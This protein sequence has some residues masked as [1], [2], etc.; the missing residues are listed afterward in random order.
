MEP[1]DPSPVDH[2]TFQAMVAPHVGR[3]LAYLDRH[4]PARLRSFV[5]PQDVAQD[6][7]FEAA[8]SWHRVTLDG[9]ESVWR[10]LVTIARHRLINV[11]QAQQA[12]KRGGG[13]RHA[14]AAGAAADAS[15]DSVIGM[16]HDLAAHSRT[17]SQSAAQRELLVLLDRCVG[18]LEPAY[19]DAIRTRYVQGLSLKETAERLGRT[20]DATQK[21]C[22]RGLQSLR[23]GL[24]SFSHYA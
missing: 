18:Q 8:R 12:A 17:P 11:I 10:W 3:L 13:L 1:V 15:H 21:L 9:P 20:E 4:I 5:D 19:R 24:R 14:G 23:S 22:A 7:F 6:A 2:G 16:L